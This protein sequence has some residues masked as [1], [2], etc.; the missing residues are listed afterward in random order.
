MAMSATYSLTKVLDAVINA[1]TYVYSSAYLGNFSL[2]DTVIDAEI[3]L[4]R[5]GIS[6]A[7]LRLMYYRWV[8]G[9]SQKETGALNGYTR[10]AVA[11]AEERARTKIQTVLDSW[12]EEDAV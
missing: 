1:D 9:Y 4:K 8:L 7:H 2:V 11:K 3:A 12:V 5:A 6:E 10:D